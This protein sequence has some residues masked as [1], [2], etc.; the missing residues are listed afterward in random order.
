MNL[1]IND[2]NQLIQK[3]AVA[4]A[5]FFVTSLLC[6]LTTQQLQRV[7]AVFSACAQDIMRHIYR[8]CISAI[9][10]LVNLPSGYELS[11]EQVEQ[12]RQ[13]IER[14]GQWLGL[15]TLRY[16]ATFISKRDLDFMFLINL[17]FEQKTL[18]IVSKLICALFETQYQNLNVQM[19]VQIFHPSNGFVLL[20]L[21]Y[22][23]EKA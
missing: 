11:P 12:R 6:N 10:R 23:Q 8:Y 17:S 18:S 7:F 13:K 20:L 1:A 15:H 5:E 4:L 3:D 21:N 9:L 2:F 16:D 19:N 22:L 14:V